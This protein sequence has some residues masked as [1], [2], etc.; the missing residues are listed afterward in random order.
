MFPSLSV[1][2][3]VRDEPEQVV[4]S[5]PEVTQLARVY[6]YLDHDLLTSVGA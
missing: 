1:G 2:L 5:C 6:V 4:S 3:G